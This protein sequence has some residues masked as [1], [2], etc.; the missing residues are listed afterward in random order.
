MG[1]I[2]GG[3]VVARYLKEVE[4]IDTIFSLSGGHIMP[5]Y[6]G[7]LDYDIRII[8]VRHEQAAAMMAHACPF[9]KA[10]RGY[11]W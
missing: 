11:A 4:G 1:E 10:S 9:I 6:D 2:H 3:H 5:V 7:C 8:D